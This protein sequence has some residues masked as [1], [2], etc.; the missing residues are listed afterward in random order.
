[1]PA[2]D[3]RHLIRP[4]TRTCSA[5]CGRSN[6][7]AAST[8]ERRLDNPATLIPVS[9]AD[10]TSPHIPGPSPGCGSRVKT[11]VSGFASPD[12]RKPLRVVGQPPG[13]A[14][15]VSSA[16][17]IEMLGSAAFSEGGPSLPTPAEVQCPDAPCNA[18][19]DG[20]LC[21]WSGKFKK[22]HQAGGQGKP[23]PGFGTVKTACTP[24]EGV[25]ESVENVVSCV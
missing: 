21:R 20:I 17:R 19:N 15:W 23:V 10:P 14:V 1:M 8:G 3:A 5:T 4:S 6:A 7:L 13:A 18:T 25:V 22:A 2:V 9:M 16:E 12:R 11:G 24:A